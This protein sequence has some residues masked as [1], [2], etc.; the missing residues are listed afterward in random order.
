M[1]PPSLPAQRPVRNQLRPSLGQPVSSSKLTQV[2]ASPSTTFQKSPGLNAASPSGLITRLRST[3]NFRPTTRLWAKGI[4][5]FE[6][7][8]QKDQSRCR[9]ASTWPDRFGS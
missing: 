9:A 7:F 8:V 1:S 3:I 5:T 4:Q 2:S 6:S